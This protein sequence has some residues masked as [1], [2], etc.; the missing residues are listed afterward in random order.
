MSPTVSPRRRRY[1][2]AIP[3]AMHLCITIKSRK[4]SNV[5]PCIAA[6][7]RYR[8]SGETASRRG[9]P[10]SREAA[11]LRDRQCRHV[12]TLILA[13]PLRFLRKHLPYP[14]H[15][16]AEE[17]IA[18]YPL[19]TAHN[20][21]LTGNTPYRSNRRGGQHYYGSQPRLT[22]FTACLPNFTDFSLFPTLQH[23]QLYRFKQ[24]S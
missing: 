23:S 8:G 19:S 1:R 2:H 24:N 14:R 10:V 15:R 9:S 21:T 3:W 12:V 4:R 5:F 17:D 22:N 13:E 11:F 16:A 6:S 20:Y 18:T 7:A